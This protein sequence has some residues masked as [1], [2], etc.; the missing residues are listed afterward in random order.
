MDY[1][2]EKIDYLRSSIIRWGKA[3]YA[4]FIWR[5]TDNHWHAL[6]AEVMLQRTRAEQVEPIF[7]EFCSQYE[8]P[9]D[10]VEKSDGSTFENLGLRWREPL[11]MELAESLAGKDIPQG[12]QD[13]KS[14]PGIGDYIAA[15]YRSMHL[16]LR[17]T[18]I[19]SNIVRFYGRFFGFAVDPETRRKRWF[20]DLAEHITPDKEFREYNYGMLDFT[21]NICRPKP[22]CAE[23]PLQSRCAYFQ[24]VVNEA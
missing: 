11:L 22:L 16:G 4:K 14:L 23:C 15:A 7:I 24:N 12:N 8:T 1:P 6:V 3:N 5:A 21:R 10:Y 19:D 20:R 17:D 9:A 2:Q 18:I 13:L